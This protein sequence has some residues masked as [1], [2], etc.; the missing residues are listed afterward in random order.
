MT[1]VSVIQYYS[2]LD[3]IALFNSTIVTITN[4]LIRIHGDMYYWTALEV[5][6]CYHVQLSNMIIDMNIKVHNMMGESIL[7]DMW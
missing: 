3:G 6:N 4:F 5:L 7:S 1:P 2:A